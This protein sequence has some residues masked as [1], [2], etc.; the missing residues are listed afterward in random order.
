[1]SCRRFLIETKSEYYNRL[2]AV[3][4]TAEWE[5]WVLYVLRG[6]AQTARMTHD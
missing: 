3:T 1:M 6:V 2:R 4:A 5:P